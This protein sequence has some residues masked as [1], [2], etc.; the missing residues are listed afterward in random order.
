MPPKR[1]VEMPLFSPESVSRPH[2]KKKTPP[3][4]SS[5]A[6]TVKDC[7]PSSSSS[8]QSISQSSLESPVRVPRN[9]FSRKG[10]HMVK[11]VCTEDVVPPKK[12]VTFD[13]ADYS[14]DPA[15]L[16][17][18]GSSLPQSPSTSASTSSSLP[19]GQSLSILMSDPVSPPTTSSTLTVSTCPGNFF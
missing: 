12:R 11:P 5:T 2:R 7:F 14:V 10:S 15:T 3:C 19:F 1:L 6:R 16:L 4:S 18:S 8:F 13:L 17:P 9:R